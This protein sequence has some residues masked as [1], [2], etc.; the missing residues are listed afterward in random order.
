MLTRAVLGRSHGA[1]ADPLNGMKWE[2]I[3]WDYAVRTADRVGS[4][5]L[6]GVALAR[7]GTPRPAEVD[8]IGR[9]HV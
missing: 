4:L 8:R 6:L 2:G 5:A 7:D 3:D 1:A 9:A